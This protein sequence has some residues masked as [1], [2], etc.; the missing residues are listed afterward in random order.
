MECVI[1]GGM[2]TTEE[3]AFDLEFEKVGAES[4]HYQVHVACFAAWELV[5][6]EAVHAGDLLMRSAGATLPD[7]VSDHPHPGPRR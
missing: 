1:C 6:E 4:T 2:L 3:M 7:D 5:R